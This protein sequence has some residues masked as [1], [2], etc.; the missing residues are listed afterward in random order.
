MAFGNK[1]EGA[2]KKNVEIFKQIRRKINHFDA[3]KSSAHEYTCILLI[4]E[5]FFIFM[6]KQGFK[7]YIL[8]AVE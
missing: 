3:F 1:I 2:K 6:E 8:H 5:E 7:K 4:S